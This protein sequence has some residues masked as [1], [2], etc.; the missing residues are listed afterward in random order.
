MMLNAQ[1][2]MHLLNLHVFESKHQN[3]CVNGTVNLVSLLLLKQRMYVIHILQIYTPHK[4][5]LPY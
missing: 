4:Y 5:V 3:S 1:V 2:I